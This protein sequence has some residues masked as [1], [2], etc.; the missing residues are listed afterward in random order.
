VQDVGQ[1]RGH[2]PYQ[3]LA[4]HRQTL[5]N[6]L[7]QLWLCFRPYTRPLR[8]SVSRITTYFVFKI[9][10]KKPE[11]DQTRLSFPSKIGSY[12]PRLNPPKSR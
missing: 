10:L 12:L 11:I 7:Q 3:V 5:E 9:S 4:H 8:A 2:C 6:N 1:I